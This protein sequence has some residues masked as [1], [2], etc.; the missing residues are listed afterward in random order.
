MGAAAQFG[1]RTEVYDAYAVAVFLA[2]E[3]DGAHG[4]GLLHGGITLLAKREVAADQFIDPFLD[5]HGL[6]VG[7]LGEMA[8]VEA[9]VI[10][11]DVGTLLLD[12]GAEDLAQGG[13]HQVGGR[14]VGG[15]LEPACGVDGQGERL[16]AVLRQPLG[17]VDGQVVFLDGVEDGDLLA[18]LGLDPARVTD[19][20]AHFRIERGA[21]EDQLEEGLVLLLDD[22]LLQKGGT[23]DD[24]GVIAEE[25]DFLA[26]A[27]LGPVAE[28]VGGG[29]AGT[30]LLLGQFGLEAVQVDG[31][32]ALGGD[33]FGQVDRE[34]VGVIE[35]EG[36]GAGNLL[37]AGGFGHIVVQ[38]ADAAVEGAQEGHLLFTDDAFDQFLLGRKFRIGT[39]HVGDQ[40]GNEAAEERLGKT[41]EGIAVADGAAQDAADDIAGLDVGRQL[42]VGDGEGDGTDVVGADAHGHVGLLSVMVF[43]AAEFFQPADQAAEDVGLVVA[44]LALE[45]HAEALET[46]AGVDAL[47]RKRLEVAVGFAVV[48][49]EHQVPD[50][51]DLVVVGVDEAGARDRRNLGV[52]TQVDVDL[53][54]RT[55]RA[56]VAHFPEIVMLVAEQ[57]MVGGHVPEPGL[58]GLLVQGGAVFG[59]AFEHGGVQLGLVD[60]VH[61]GQ[62]FPGPVDGLGLEI[63]AET[64]VAQHLEHGVVPSVVAHG[65]EVIVLSADAQA[66][67]AVGGA[68]ELRGG[69]AQEN[70][71]E[72]VHA[73][74][75][76]HQGRVV[77]DDHRGGGDHGVALGG[78]EVEILPAYFLCCH[79]QAGVFHSILQR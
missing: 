73:R 6:L 37:G 1:R 12:V 68:G 67:L 14:M 54:A 41:E 8:E 38:H 63:V 40:L 45:H 15:D 76:E 5:R 27:E 34:A 72:L 61:F 31:V 50:L 48:L 65:F 23:F 75:G 51:D 60:L 44:G 3:G 39:A 42:A 13:V 35:D 64:P 77:L 79:I 33:Q 26:A 7:H 4:V 21:V 32:A 58:A 29:G 78:E 53:A 47:G 55:A 36:V 71:L 22:T 56:G 30:L 18:A 25:F 52:G 11:A 66:L 69:V 49:H 17:D 20:A 62:Q 43:L 2:E 16:G 46:Q 57:D 24:G 10:G 59:A 9:Q 70:V 19:L 28:F 74:V